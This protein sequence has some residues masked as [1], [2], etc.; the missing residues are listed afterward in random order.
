[1]TFIVCNVELD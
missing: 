1:M